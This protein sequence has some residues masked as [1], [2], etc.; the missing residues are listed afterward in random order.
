M[1]DRLF[2]KDHFVF[3]SPQKSMMMIFNKES[4]TLVKCKSPV[5]FG[6][7]FNIEVYLKREGDS[8]I[9]TFDGIDRPVHCI[10]ELAECVVSAFEILHYH[11]FVLKNDL[12]FQA[13]LAQDEADEHICFMT[14]AKKQIDEM[15]G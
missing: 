5:F 7:R 14:A 12:T 8:L 2:D 10:G 1:F 11:R 4:E 15:L 6:E 3:G 9:L 13:I